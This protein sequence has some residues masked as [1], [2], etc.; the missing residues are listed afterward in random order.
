M[1]TVG[2]FA[3]LAGVSAKVLRSYDGAGLFRPAWVDPSS[4]YRFYSPAQL[5]SLRRLLALRDLG[6]SRAELAEATRGDADLRLAL[7]RRRQAL[8]A[9]R[10]AIERRLAMLDIRVG[11][12]DDADVVVRALEPEP[13]ATFD[14]RNAPG[15]DISAAFHELEAHV[16]DL[17]T[18]AP[19]PP[20]AIPDEDLIYVPVRRLGTPTDRVAFRRLPAGRAATLLHRGPYGSLPDA[21]SSLSAWVSR[22]GHRPVAPIRVLYLQ[23][24][25][26]T[27]L[28]LPRGWTVEDDADFV[29]ELQ[30]PIE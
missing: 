2:A 20:G 19:R 7:E 4:G 3:R 12:A 24:G 29:T 1:F 13:I 25:A 15:D 14:L 18:R 5:P 30:Q 28:R 9:D 26:E 8:E 16:R 22:S 23:F 11:R 27:D 10:A 17:A 21:F 6:M